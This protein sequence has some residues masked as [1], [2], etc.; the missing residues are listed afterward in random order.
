VL[1]LVKRPTVVRTHYEP[2]QLPKPEN[3]SFHCFYLK[4]DLGQSGSIPWRWKQRSREVDVLVEQRLRGWTGSSMSR[5]APPSQDKFRSN[6]A[7]RI[8]D[9]D[10]LPSAKRP[11]E[12]GNNGELYFAVVSAVAWPNQGCL[13]LSTRPASIPRTG[14]RRRARIRSC[15]LGVNHARQDVDRF[16]IGDVTCSARAVLVAMFVLSYICSSVLGFHGSN[17]RAH[18]FR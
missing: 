2:V 11:H 10:D 5:T 9:L 6:R 17:D 13:N 14:C 8:P 1:F 15:L 12:T 4:M 16:V 18:C 7:G 3:A